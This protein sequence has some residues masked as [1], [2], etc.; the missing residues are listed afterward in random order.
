M[1]DLTWLFANKLNF[2]D[3]VKIVTKTENLQLYQSQFVE[4]LI[5]EFWNENFDKIFW[6]CFVPHI[7]YMVITHF[8]LLHVLDKDFFL[9]E[10]SE[11]G[12]NFWIRFPLGTLAIYSWAYQVNIEYQQIKLNGLKEYITDM[13]NFSDMI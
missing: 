6:R 9:S 5:V 4:A 10:K 13:Y 7:F 8:Y 11:N 1:I 12:V 3:F 2:V